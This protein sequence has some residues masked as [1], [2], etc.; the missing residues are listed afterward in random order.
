MPKTLLGKWSVGLIVLFFVLLGA[1]RVV[2][3]AT[4]GGGETF[5]DNIPLALTMLG[6]G[7]AGVAAFFIG[8]IAV[9]KQHERSVLVYIA[10]LIGFLFLGFTLGELLGPEH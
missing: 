7:I 6:A 2:A 4:G 1:G 5:F 9:I 3:V 8:L 10:M